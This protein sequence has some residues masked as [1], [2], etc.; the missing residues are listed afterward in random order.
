MTQWF[1]GDLLT[2]NKSTDFQPISGS[3]ETAINDAGS[4]SATVTLRDADVRMLNLPNAATVGKSYLAVAENDVIL[5][6]GPIW[7]HQYNRDTGELQFTAAGLWSYFDHRVLIPVLANGQT[8]LDVDSLY[9]NMSLA[10]IAKR[11]VAQAQTHTG[12]NV[13]V[14][15]PADI[16]GSETREW[17]GADLTLIGDALGDLV[18]VE[19]GPEIDF[20]PRWRSDRLGIE[21]V[22]RTGT[23]SQPQLYGMTTHVWDYSV[24]QPSIKGLQ[25]TRDGSKVTGRGWAASGSASDAT[26]FSSYSNTSLLNQGYPLL[27]VVET[28]RDV[29]E[30]G[31]LDSYVREL[32][33]TGSKPREFWSFQVQADQSPLIGEYAKGDYCVVKMRRD[34]YIPDGEYRRRITNL[35]GDHD[36]KWVKVTTGEVYSLNG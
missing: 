25:V 12:G 5:N 18:S 2:G 28:A 14:V 29:D 22:M 3:W 26:M 30:Q 11:L 7:Q 20:Q 35:S 27:E 19:N 23:P 17:P 33:R 34:H 9:E 24:P 6:A 4:I 8:P 36:G 32:A 15:L 10:T 16:S 1:I 13:P 21:W 31:Q